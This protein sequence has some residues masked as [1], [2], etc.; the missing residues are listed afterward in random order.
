MI[1]ARF[2]A[3]GT[4]EFEALFAPETP[5]GEVIVTFL[6]L[7]ELVRLRVLRV[8]QEERF[9]AITL[10]LAVADLDEATA[11]VRDVGQLMTRWRGGDSPHAN[12][13]SGDPS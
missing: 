4:V 10:V 6:A 5:R 9:G 12:R 7:L 11:R 2:T 8:L 1:L 13:S 3:G